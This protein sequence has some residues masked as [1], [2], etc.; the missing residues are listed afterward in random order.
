MGGFSHTS[1]KNNAGM[2]DQARAISD[3]PLLNV[4]G[5][6]VSFLLRGGAMLRAVDGVDFDVRSGEVHGLVGE[7]GCGKTVM[8]LSVLGLLDV[9][10]AK[11]EGE[12]HWRGRNLVG[13]PERKFRPVRGREIAMVFQ[14]APASLNPALRIGTQMGALLRLHRGLNGSGAEREAERLL[15]AVRIP[16]PAR[17]LRAYAHE[18]SGGMAQRIALAMALAC[19]PRLLIADEP[20]AAL[21]VTIA[22]QIIELLRAVREEFGLSILL[23][24]HDLGVVARLCD[25]VSVMYLGKIVESAPTR[26]LFAQPL[27]PYTDALLGS[28]F[29]PDSASVAPVPVL[30]GE[31]PSPVNIPSGC[32]FHPRCPK[33]FAPCSK[34][35]PTLAVVA[36]N[37]HLA[38]CWL[39]TPP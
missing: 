35:Q 34:L 3:G 18:C 2:P 6:R 26:E 19:R 30:A 12:I 8:A 9:S 4:K 5:L 27:H 21:D 25:R 38:A 16:D 20:T 10:G 1:T 31:V 29:V 36:P 33:I 22:A 15:A 11:V 39:N 23:I 17:I 28:A 14:N 32:R 37:D 13:L 24:S 7:S